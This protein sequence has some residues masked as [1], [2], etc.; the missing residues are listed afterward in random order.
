MATYIKIASATITQNATTTN[1]KFNNLPQ[2]FTDLMIVGSTRTTR[3]LYGIDELLVYLNNDFSN[4]LYSHTFARWQ[5][6]GWDSGRSASVPWGPGGTAASNTAGQFG[7][8]RMILNNYSS[9]T[10]FKSYISDM[11]APSNATSNLYSILDSGTWRSTAA[12]TSIS[13]ASQATQYDTYSTITIYGIK[14]S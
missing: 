9:T 1:I 6:S 12:V 5:P 3:G 7:N 4:T 2:N 11:T 8:G 13:F 14:N 10:G